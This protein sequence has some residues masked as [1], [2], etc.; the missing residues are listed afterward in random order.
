VTRTRAGRGPRA[1]LCLSPYP[2]VWS[3]LQD[4]VILVTEP[5]SNPGVP[6]S[7]FGL[8]RN[9]QSLPA[10]AQRAVKGPRC[11]VERGSGACLPRSSA[12]RRHCV[13]RWP[14][15]TTTRCQSLTPQMHAF[16][17][18]LG[19]PVLPPERGEVPGFRGRAVVDRGAVSDE[20][21]DKKGPFR[22]VGRC[23]QIPAYRF[24]RPSF[25]FKGNGA[26]QHVSI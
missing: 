3:F 22:R 5:P 26:E 24:G 14:F 10:I 16:G 4:Q 25:H 21:A 23:W 15:N 11:A 13:A 1:S 17:L 7:V 6:E 2:A 8:E 18:R 9:T 12:T 20:V 19:G